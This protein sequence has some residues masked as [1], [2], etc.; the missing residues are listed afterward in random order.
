MKTK[1]AYKAFYWQ[2]LIVLTVFVFTTNSQIRAQTYFG[3]QTG[4]NLSTFMYEDNAKEELINDYRKVKI[5]FVAGFA[6]R[7]NLNKVLFVEPELTYSR[8][9]LK[10]VQPGFSE[11]RTHMNFVEIPV[12]AGITLVHN[13]FAPGS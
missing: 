11:G 3:I 4:V 5:D 1:K 9:G 13:R 2:T 8:K 6:F 12:L 7:Y 10:Y